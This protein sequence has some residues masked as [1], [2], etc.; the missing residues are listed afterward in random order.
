MRAAIRDYMGE[1]NC[2][3]AHPVQ[4]H[5][6]YQQC[7]KALKRQEFKNAESDGW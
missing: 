6:A 5:E 1:A 3:K 7:F 2:R 4:E